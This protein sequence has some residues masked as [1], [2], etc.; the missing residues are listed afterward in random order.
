MKKKSK[1]W[2]LLPIALLAS[3]SMLAEKAPMEWTN[4][5][6]HQNM[7]DQLGITQ[8]R[9]P[10]NG[11]AKVGEKDAANYDESIAN[12]FDPLPEALTLNNGKKVKSKK[13]WWNKRRPE[14]VEHFERE[15][16]GRLPNNIP[17]VTW[18]VKET[19]ASDAQIGGAPVI[20]KI[21]IG[22]VDNSAAP[23]LNVDIEMLVVTPAHAKG[24]VPL[25][26][27]FGRRSPV[28]PMNVED[29][30]VA[31]AEAEA[32]RPDTNPHPRSTEQLIKAGWGYASI[33]TTSIQADNGAGLTKGIIGLTNLGQPRK[34]DDWGSLRAWAWG[35]AR[36]LDYLETDDLVDAKRVGIEGVSRY[37]KAALVTIAFES[38]FAIA[39]IGSSGAGGAGIHRR[40][41]GERVENLT[42][43]GEY[44][45]MAGNYMKYGTEESSF[46]R[47]DANDMSVESHEL[48]A[49]CAPRPT[50]ISYGIPE[51]G[52]SLW[53][54]QHGSYM[55]TVAAGPV[56]KLLGAKDIGDE[57][58]YMDA[59]MPPVQ[60]GLLDGQL[61]WRQHE[62]GHEDR[63]NMS[64]FIPWANQM[65]ED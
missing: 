52:D 35:A 43:S 13:A 64:S 37:G 20:G 60:H 55:A 9:P 15:V 5:Q 25:L 14:I 6:D 39:L 51:Q 31:R 1:N 29:A 34:P 2:I 3:T 47:M 22:H 28:L 17:D 7:Q 53:L 27:M 18:S 41:F 46:G 21:L 32:R 36:G 63:S 30:K 4:E 62:G 56:F 33:I 50:F 24:P 49:L 42:S 23:S 58:N 12:N 54:D 61:A 65:L 16:Y 40:D 57:S 26:M 11:W 19:T 38:R 44:H 10:A 45:W 8:L 48:I 59:K